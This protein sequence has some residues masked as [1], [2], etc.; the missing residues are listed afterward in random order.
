MKLG[1]TRSHIKCK[2]ST[3]NDR[4]F[5]LNLYNVYMARASAQFNIYVCIENFRLNWIL[6]KVFKCTMCVCV[7]LSRLEIQNQWQNIFNA[8][9]FPFSHFCCCYRNWISIEMKTYIQFYEKFS[10]ISWWVRWIPIR[11]LDQNGK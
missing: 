6:L 4:I 9:M 1:T 10:C 11:C 7:C 8:R 5:A 3:K 2:F